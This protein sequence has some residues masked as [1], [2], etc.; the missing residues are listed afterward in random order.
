M[1]IEIKNYFC[2]Q[3]FSILSVD[4]ERRNLRSCNVAAAQPI[5]LSWLSHNPGQLFNTPNLQNER[6]QM[7]NN[8]P[9]ASCE[10]MCWSAERQGLPSRRTM[11]QTQTSQLLPIQAQPTTLVITLGSTCNLTCVYCCKEF[12]TAWYRDIQEHGDY[13]LG[14]RFQI[15]VKDKIVNRLSQGEHVA[16]EGYDLLMQEIAKFD[17]VETVDFAGGE[18]FLYNHMPD[19]VNSLPTSTH[20]RLF[21]GLG[22][23]PVRFQQQLD[24]INDWSNITVF[25]SAE[26][27]GDRYEFVRYGNS[28]DK[29]LTNLNL[30]RAHGCQVVFRSVISNTTVFDIVA[31]KKYFAEYEVTYQF[32]A[33]PDFLAVNVL[34]QQTK[35]ELIENFNA[36]D[37]A[38]KDQIIQALEQPYTDQQKSQFQQYLQEF[39]ARRKLLLNIFPDSMTHWL[40][41]EQHHVVQ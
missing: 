12:S 38:I 36:S 25:V 8:Q 34:D 7:L 13:S 10:D 18:P 15:T 6:Q 22:V 14:N 24:K 32:C 31:F 40:E 41:L 26:T 20:I 16:S 39:A 23:N 28:F 4:F 9:A 37:V 2:S 27:L 17:S 30:L 33:E 29:F 1:T 21:T 35:H 3:K 19:I 11:M 5:D